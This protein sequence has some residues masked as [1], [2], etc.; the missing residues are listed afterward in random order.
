[1]GRP[2]FHVFTLDELVAASHA[3]F[4]GAWDHPKARVD[5]T[6]GAAF[7]R[8][9]VMEALDENPFIGRSMM[10]EALYLP[11]SLPALIAGA[12]IGRRRGGGRQ[13]GPRLLA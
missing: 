11:P 10:S 2:V 1:M 7:H 5:E 6:T 9:R 8:V 12:H 4:V 13:E 3:I